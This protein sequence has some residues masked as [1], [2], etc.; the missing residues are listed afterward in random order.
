MQK[1]ITHCFYLKHEKALKTV[2]SKK[3][4]YTRILL[5]IL[6]DIFFL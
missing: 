6:A 3:A 2:D 4:P 1:N 5:E